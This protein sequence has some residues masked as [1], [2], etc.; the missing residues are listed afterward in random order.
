MVNDRP[1][2]DYYIV[3]SGETSAMTLDDLLTAED[4]GI[5]MSKKNSELA[6]KVDEALT[7]LKENGEYDKIYKKWFGEKK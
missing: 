4:Y 1:V 5:A 7:K 3:K 2:N 6:K